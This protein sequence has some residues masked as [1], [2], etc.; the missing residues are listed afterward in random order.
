MCQTEI[1][2]IDDDDGIGPQ[3]VHPILDNG[4]REKNIIFS[5]FEGVDA[6]FDHLS[7]HLSMSDDHVH[8]FIFSFSNISILGSLLLD[9]F[10]ASYNEFYFFLHLLH[11]TDTIVDDD[12]LSITFELIFYCMSN[13]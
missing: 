11:A 5:F 7:W 4:G 12:D 8:F 10:R 13:S 1:F 2:R 6:L 3:E 9:S